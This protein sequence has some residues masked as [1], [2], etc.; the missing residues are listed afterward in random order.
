MPVNQLTVEEQTLMLAVDG[1]QDLLIVEEPEIQILL[2]GTQGPPGVAGASGSSAYGSAE[3][4]LVITS[5]LETTFTL[6]VVPRAGTL[7]LYLNGLRES[8]LNFS[9]LGQVVSFAGLARSPGD[10][11]VFDYQYQL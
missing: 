10:S 5:A 7:R 3:E 8:A 4:L 6:A 9:L 11:V 2:V 1:E